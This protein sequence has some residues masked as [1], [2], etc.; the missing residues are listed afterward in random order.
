MAPWW[1]PCGMTMPSSVIFHKETL[2]QNPSYLHNQATVLRVRR[3]WAFKHY[4]ACRECSIVWYHWYRYLTLHLHY[5]ELE[6]L[7][8]MVW[9]KGWCQL[10]VSNSRK[11]E[12]QAMGHQPLV[13]GSISHTHTYIYIWAGQLWYKL[14]SHKQSV[15]WGEKSTIHVLG[16]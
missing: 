12:V 10:Q 5:W 11:L 13:Y 1:S 15:M 6:D 7:F 16:S 4:L 2:C 9:M 14:K 8:D 3:Q